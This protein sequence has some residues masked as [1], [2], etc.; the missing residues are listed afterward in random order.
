M[1]IFA[2]EYDGFWHIN[3]LIVFAKYCTE[4][5]GFWYF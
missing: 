2:S 5:R 1:L 3:S 4:T